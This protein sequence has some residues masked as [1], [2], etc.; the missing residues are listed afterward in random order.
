[1]ASSA[2][3]T[4]RGGVVRSL[5][6]GRA[7]W[8]PVLLF[9]GFLPLRI[10]FRARFL[11]N[12]DAVNFAL[13][14]HLFSLQHHQP[15]PP[16]YIGYVA[17][18]WLL[19]H[20]TGDANTSLTLLSI[21]SGAAAPAGFFLLASVFMPRAY[22]LSSAILFGLSPVV[23]YYSG[24]ALTYSVEL[25]LALF[26][27]W[28]GY[29]GRRQGSTRHILIAT[30]ILVVLGAMRPSGALFL[31]PLWLYLVWVLPWRQRLSVTAVLVAGNLAWLLPLL[32][33]SGGIASFLRASTEL[34]TL[35]VVPTS[36][37]AS[38]GTSH[39]Q[40]QNI[41]F[42][43]LGLLVG[44][45][46]GLLLILGGLFANLRAFKVFLRHGAFLLLWLTPAVLTYL[47]LH[48]GQLGYVLLILPAFYLMVG[49]ALRGIAT[50]W[51]EWA[52]RAGQRAGHALRR[53]YAIASVVG[54][55]AVANVA[56]FLLVPRVLQRV[57]HPGDPGEIAVV[58]LLAVAPVHRLI[59]NLERAGIGAHP[60][61]FNIRMSDRYWSDL[62][63]FVRQYEPSRSAILTTPNGRGSF[64]H[65]TYYLP[66][67]RVYGLG[68][69]LGG[70]FGHLFTAYGGTSDY[71]VEGLKSA[72]K[73]LQL[74]PTVEW[75][76]I[77]DR[78]IQRRLG[79]LP[80]IEVE[81]D[82]G[83]E[84]A[85]VRVPPGTTLVVQDTDR[86]GRVVV[87]STISGGE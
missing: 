27:L 56:T 71:A 39:G 1:M 64:R 66:D 36:V 75:L 54:L 33:L 3:K 5:E 9:A 57:S 58:D 69:D 32:W 76:L 67:Y 30:V 51:R 62:I 24:V 60:R 18:G 6:S 74:P 77:P 63:D 87:A 7:F 83:L 50:R 53:S 25:A 82:S 73:K 49:V 55:L 79:E 17:A 10:P 44:V 11:I 12:W 21:V 52:T 48:T 38:G 28:A 13:G 16:G 4:F 23:W 61:Q 35:V 15:H 2:V 19:N 70:Q 43:L 29:V 46:L 42:L 84:V 80:T 34:V 78:P 41:A 22:A 68:R 40:S 8:I 37:F 45:N 85:L 26:F 86:G 72:R 65:L 14:T 20:V 31:M 81:L 59:S 47:L